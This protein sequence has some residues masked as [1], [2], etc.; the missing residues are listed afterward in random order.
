MR[1]LD[2][3]AGTGWGVA[4]QR[5]GIEEDGAEIM[6]E[7]IATREAAGMR[8][9]FR[10]VAE[11]PDDVA[12]RYPLHIASPPCQSFSVAGRGAGRKA[13]DDVLR[14][15]KAVAAGQQLQQGR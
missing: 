1:A 7:A 2:L 13:L 10:D 3:F 4:C 5:L 12:A 6:P 15:V 8:T 11:I 9:P 14:G